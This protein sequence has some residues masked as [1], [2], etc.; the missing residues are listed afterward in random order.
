MGKSLKIDIIF[1]WE[2]GLLI[3]FCGMILIIYGISQSKKV[4]DDFDN[5]PL[6]KPTTK[7]LLGSFALIVGLVQ[8][9]PLLKNI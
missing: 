8:L 1:S 4:Q 7:I 2:I 3:I 9:L 6:I 5:F